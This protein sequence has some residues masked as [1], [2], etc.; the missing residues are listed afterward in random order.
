MLVFMYL[1]AAI[2]YMCSKGLGV[3]QFPKYRCVFHQS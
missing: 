1:S 2:I 3:F